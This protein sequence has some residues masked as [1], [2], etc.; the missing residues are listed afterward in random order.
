MKTERPDVV[1]ATS[2]SALP[3]WAEV[4]VLDAR[5]LGVR[6]VPVGDEWH[7]TRDLDATKRAVVYV[8]VSTKRQAQRAGSPEGYSLPIQLQDCVR[9]ATTLDARV[10]AVYM[11]KDTG[12]STDKRPQMQ[13]LLDRV[14]TKQDVDYVIVFKLERW[15]RN[16]REDL[17]ADFTLETAHCQ[18]VSCSETIDRSAAGRL[19]HGMLASVNE[20]QSRN[21]SDEIRRKTVGKAKAGGTP[22]LAPIGYLN[23]QDGIDVR[24]VVPD[25]ER[26]PFITWMYEVY[27]TGEWSLDAIVD[28]LEA[29]GLRSRGNRRYAPKP[30]GMS[31]VQRILTN[32]YY[33][34][35]VTYDG[36]QYEGT[37][38][39][40]VTP[41]LWQ[42]VQDMLEYRR[43]GEK[44]RKHHHYLKGTLVCGH[45]HSRI[46]VTHAQ[47]NGGTYP[48]FFCLG[49]HQKRTTC[50]LKARPMALV[51]EQMEAYYRNVKL[52][53]DLLAR[54][55]DELL[56]ELASERK[57]ADD[58]RERQARRLGDL[59]EQRKKLLDAYY[60][61]AISVELLKEEQ[62]KAI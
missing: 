28:E 60:A 11:D 1:Q 32:P 49:R 30:L 4:E 44:Q 14:R 58:E 9:K 45:C 37:H 47:G 39:P 20:Y 22:C 10:V 7:I 16:T 25:P 29:R 43:N 8:R 35:I 38:E 40:L 42:R 2:V 5:T 18:L 56:D 12:T 59:K 23:K 31:Q 15:A 46:C 52:G 26:A 17:I 57:Q 55:R 50:T 13:A 34:G 36:V 19:L 27:A 53:A 3:W 6:V 24:Y 62:P 51:E 41:E 61:G 21:Q 54:T 48:Y 33:K